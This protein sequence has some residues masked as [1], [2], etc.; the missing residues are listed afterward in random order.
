MGIGGAMDIVKL[1][2]QQSPAL[3]AEPTRRALDDFRSSSIWPAAFGSALILVCAALKFLSVLDLSPGPYCAGAALIIRSLLTLLTA[4]RMRRALETH[5]WTRRLAEVR[6]DRVILLRDP[7]SDTVLHLKHPRIN[8]TCP[9]ENGPLWWAGTPEHGGVVSA[10]G[11][12]ALTWVRPLG[13]R[14]A[15]YRW[16]LLLGLVVGG[17]GIAGSEAADHDPM[18]ELK[19]IDHTTKPGP[20][21]V[22]FKDPLTHEHRTASFICEGHRDALIPDL[23]YGWVVSYGPW[24][25]DLYNADWEGS[26]GNDVNDGL[27]SA[28][29]LL[30]AAGGIGGTVSYRERR[31]F[32]AAGTSPGPPRT[33]AARPAPRSSRWPA[34]AA[35]CAASHEP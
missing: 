16:V 21:R 15:R 24:K 29:V 6:D 30:A 32:P 4:H 27:I 1:P 35:P 22:G 13:G 34:P 14:R 12:T 10:P 11:G 7:E 20:C 28:G 9:T 17:L 33:P 3:G 26:T 25:G 5:P 19:V 18:V 8:P 23:E 31:H 2:E